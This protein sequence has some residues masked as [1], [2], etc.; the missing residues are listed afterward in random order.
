MFQAFGVQPAIN[1]AHQAAD[2]GLTGRP[3]TDGLGS[4]FTNGVLGTLG[5]AAAAHIIGIG[6]RSAT[7]TA[8]RKPDEAAA[9]AATVKKPEEAA[10][11]EAGT[12]PYPEA[13]HAFFKPGITHVYKDGVLQFFDPAG[14]FLA[15]LKDGTLVY[16]YDG[17]GG[18]IVAAPDRATTVLGRFHEDGSAAGMGTRQFLGNKNPPP[19]DSF[20][21]GTITRGVGGIPP[22]GGIHFLDLPE[23]EYEANRLRH[24]ER[25]RTLPENAGKTNAKIERLG[26][27]AWNDEFWEKYNLPYLKESFERGYNIRLISDP[28][29]HDKGTYKKELDAIK[30]DGS[31]EGLAEKYG[32]IYDDATK[33]YVKK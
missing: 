15:Y 10:P 22:K 16:K 33:T 4:A 17:F 32:Y 24:V 1:M 12:P 8:A 7:A 23:A 3:V 5:P 9:P 2:N 21:E 25:Q 18:D 26:T 6:A 19:V 31:T 11:P 14:R 20:P 30:G 13:A 27:D 29:A 28:I